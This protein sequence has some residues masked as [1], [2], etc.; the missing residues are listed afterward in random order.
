MVRLTGAKAV[1]NAS[2]RWVPFFLVT[3]EDAFAT[4]TAVLAAIIGFGEMA[5]LSTILV[6]NRLD[7]GNEHRVTVA[8]LLA[9]SI[10]GLI[11]L[12]GSVVFFAASFVLLMVGAA[13]VNVGM[14]SWISARVGFDRRAR[15]IGTVETSWA[16]GLLVGAPVM[17]LLIGGFGWRG[18]FVG[19]SIAALIAAVVIATMTDSPPA[20]PAG[21]APGAGVRLT[22]DAWVAVAASAAVAMAGLTTIVVVGTWLNDEL[23]VSTSGIG[24]VAMAFG[25]VELISSSASAAFADRLGKGRSTRFSILVVVGGLAVMAAAGSSLLVGS[26]GLLIF[27]LGF[28]YGIVTSFSLVSEAMPSARGRAIATNSAIGTLTR[29]AGAVLAGVLY[30]AYGIHGPVALSAVAAL[31]AVGLL[32]EVDRRLLSSI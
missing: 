18:P 6:G 30:E 3:L 15:F 5:G 19:V 20:E 11:A 27:F 28:E 26:L 23:G 12:Q 10:S 17:A 31:A 24:L 8:A 25:T 7:S 2:L 29:G 9:I 16:F 22:G 21:V 1:T 4:S 32:T 13:H 14:H